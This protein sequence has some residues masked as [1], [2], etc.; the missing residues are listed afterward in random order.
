MK[1]YF[2]LYDT[3]FEDIVIALGHRLFGAGLMGFVTGPDGG[4]DAKFKGTAQAYPSTAA[5]W[6]GCTI[7]QAKHTNEINASFG[8]TAAFN[9]V[10]KTG[11]VFDELA[12]IKALVSSGEAQNYLLISNRKLSGYSEHNITQC[13]A[14]ETGLPSERFGVVGTT[15]L[16]DLFELYPAALMSAS[17]NPLESPLIVSPDDLANTI[18]G[19]SEALDVDAPDEDSS[20]PTIRTN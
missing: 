3:Q 20:H 11:L 9:P 12:R 10:K 7:L 6:V 14:S 4:R 17:L 8:D 2:D 5:P 1:P 19:F 13:I 15:L 16:D 18:E